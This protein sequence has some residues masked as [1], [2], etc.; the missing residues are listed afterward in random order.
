MTVAPHLGC[1]DGSRQPP[2]GTLDDLHR[3]TCTHMHPGVSLQPPAFR[4]ASCQHVCSPTGSQTGP[5]TG[6][7]RHT[8]LTFAGRWLAVSLGALDALLGTAALAPP[9]LLGALDA[10]S[11]VWQQQHTTAGSA[12]TR[13][14]GQG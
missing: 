6:G 12:D 5:S 4:H 10:S 8:R 9:V 11:C 1:V 2:V 14:E 13:C 7:P 3:Q